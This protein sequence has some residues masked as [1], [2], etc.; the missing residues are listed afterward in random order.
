MLHFKAANVE[1]S[2]C[3]KREEDGNM[4]KCSKCGKALSNLQNSAIKAGHQCR[5]CFY[6]SF[7]GEMIPRSR[8][9]IISDQR[10]E[11]DELIAQH[12]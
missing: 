2:A 7:P 3:L 10:R 9:V 6:E 1:T 4:P 12:H 5:E 11:F 8:H